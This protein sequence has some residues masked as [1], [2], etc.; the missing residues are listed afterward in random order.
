ME[1]ELS[2]LRQKIRQMEN[3]QHQLVQKTADAELARELPAGMAETAMAKR[4]ASQAIINAHKRGHKH[5][6][7]QVISEAL[8]CMRDRREYSCTNRVF[9]HFIYAQLTR[10]HN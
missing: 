4:V 6:M 8:P 1:E 10:A 3:E 2:R 7:H 9:P 5:R